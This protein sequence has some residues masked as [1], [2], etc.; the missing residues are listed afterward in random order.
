MT[1]SGDE[2]RLHQGPM[3]L[4]PAAAAA[5]SSPP[6]PQQQQQQLSP[7]T[8][9]GGSIST[10]TIALPR[11]PGVPLTYAGVRAIEQ[12]LAGMEAEFTVRFIVVC[13]CAVHTPAQVLGYTRQ[14]QQICT[15]RLAHY[16]CALCSKPHDSDPCPMP[17]CQSGVTATQ[18]TC[19]VP[20]ANG[21]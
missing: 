15:P 7:R 19:V 5:G 17:H 11:G 12:L 10:L 14:Q 2:E 16:G 21:W 3:K 1:C 6:S 4:S 18:R 8:S 13:H 20:F 9:R